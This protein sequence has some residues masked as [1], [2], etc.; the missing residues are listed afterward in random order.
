MSKVE[1]QNNFSWITFIT[2]IA[3]LITIAIL[4]FYNIFQ[5]SNY[6]DFGYGFR[7]ATG[8]KIVGLV[9]DNGAKSGMRIGDEIIE[10]NSKKI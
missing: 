7:S 3:L 6:P 10:I 1:K 5:W 2:C 4:Y 9:T 8:I